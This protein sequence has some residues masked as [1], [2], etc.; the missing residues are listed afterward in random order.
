MSGCIIQTGASVQQL[1]HLCTQFFKVL[2]FPLTS[3]SSRHVYL[4]LD[5]QFTDQGLSHCFGL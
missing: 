2:D 1:A 3:T 5:Q 4:G